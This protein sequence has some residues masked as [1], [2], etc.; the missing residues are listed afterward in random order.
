MDIT[1]Y[2][3]DPE[4]RMK[5]F[6]EMQHILYQEVPIIPTFESSW[7]YVQDRALKGMKRFPN[8]DFSHARLI[9]PAL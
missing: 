8:V 2:S 7:V 1:H 6:D 5:A 9:G 3:S 4:V